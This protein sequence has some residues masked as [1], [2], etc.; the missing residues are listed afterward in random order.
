MGT[1]I[2]HPV[3]DR[4]KPSFVIFD[5]RALW[6]W[7]LVSELCGDGLFLLMFWPDNFFILTAD[8]SASWL[9]LLIAGVS[10]VCMSSDLT[11]MR[12]R[13]RLIVYPL[14]MAELS[15]PT[16]MDAVRLSTEFKTSYV[17]TRVDGSA[18]TMAWAGWV[19]DL[20]KTRGI[21]NRAPTATDII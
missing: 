16:L 12:C 3:P 11:D 20:L 5:I 21:N 17:K 19:Y 13:R 1:T 9:V 7:A 8:I 6:C 18:D 4:I 10:C 15:H 14:K 2:K